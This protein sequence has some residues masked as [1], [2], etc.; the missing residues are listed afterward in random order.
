VAA[1]TTRTTPTGH[2][3]DQKVGVVDSSSPHK[4]NHFQT[5]HDAVQHMS[6]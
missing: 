6:D 1:R 5:T 3:R 2:R 4:P